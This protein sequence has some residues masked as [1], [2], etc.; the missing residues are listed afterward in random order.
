MTKPYL[1]VLRKRAVRIGE[2][3]ASCHA[4]A[5][6]PG[7]SVSCVVRWLARHSQ[8]GSVRPLS[9]RRAETS[10]VRIIQYYHAANERTPGDVERPERI[11]ERS[12]VVTLLACN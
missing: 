2:A 5:K 6:R 7:V 1:M 4:V 12:V 8:T 11:Y 9:R 10:S 3:G